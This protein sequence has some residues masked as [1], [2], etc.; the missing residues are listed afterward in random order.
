VDYLLDCGLGR[1]QL[2][3][4][5]STPSP[6]KISMKREMKK[7]QSVITSSTIQRNYAPHYMRRELASSA[8]VYHYIVMF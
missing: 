4:L 5:P 7:P 3:R 1:G 6:P 8:F 2:V